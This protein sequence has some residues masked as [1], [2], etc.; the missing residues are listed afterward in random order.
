MQFK[1]IIAVLA[2]TVAAVATP[3]EPVAVNLVA[4]T[5][6]PS[7][8]YCPAGQTLVSKCS[9]LGVPINTTSQNT[10]LVALIQAAISLGLTV[11]CVRKLL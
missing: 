3:V 2:L 11:Q 6:P 4:R 10:A 9:I 1:S 5:E 8:K 7:S